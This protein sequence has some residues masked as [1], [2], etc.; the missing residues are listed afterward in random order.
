MH[1]VQVNFSFYK[2]F[3]SGAGGGGGGGGG[4]ASRGGE[5]N[6]EAA[7]M[8]EISELEVDR[9]ILELTQ[10]EVGSRALGLSDFTH[11]LWTLWKVMASVL[12]QLGGNLTD[13]PLNL[14][15]CIRYNIFESSEKLVSVVSKHYYS[16]ILFAWYKMV[17]SMELIG[18]PVALLTNV[19]TGVHDFFYEPAQ[20][21][22]MDN[23]LKVGKGLLKGVGKGTL[24]LLGN[25]TIGVFD[26]AARITQ[27]IGG[28]VAV[29]S[30][31][32]E[33]LQRRA[34]AQVSVLV[35]VSISLSLARY[36]YRW[37][38]GEHTQLP[39]LA[40]ADSKRQPKAAGSFWNA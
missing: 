27:S 18:N 36:R 10:K 20:A 6:S 8:G 29:L 26:T 39:L 9:D 33:Y 1:P 19:G 38:V 32:D 13:A 16:Q 2:G 34:Q 28:G 37:P 17:G 30:A 5:S 3:S 35:S 21:L 11:A 4:G 14:K 24:S 22:I 25:T 31:D 23:P 12:L 7:K 40:A 15:S